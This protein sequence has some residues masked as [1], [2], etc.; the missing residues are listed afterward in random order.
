MKKNQW[1]P[2]TVVIGIAVVISSLLGSSCKKYLDV[3]PD[4]IST[5]DNAFKLRVEAEKYLFTCYSYLPKNGDGWFNASLTSADEIWYAQNDQTNWHPAFMIAEGIQ[6]VANPLF[7]EWRGD[8]KGGDGRYNYLR[9]W[10]AVRNCNIFLENMQNPAKVPDISAAERSRWIGEGLFLKAFYHFYMMRMYGPV[11]LINDNVPVDADLTT[12]YVKRAPVDECVS[13]ISA[14]LDSATARLPERIVNQNTE[15][16]R[17]TKTIALSVKARLLIMAASPLFNGNADYAGF[18]DKEGKAL[19]N[20]TFDASKWVKARDAVKAAIESAEANNFSLYTYTNDVYGLS[21]ATKTQLNIR[22]AVTQRWGQE[23][24][25]G[26]SQSYF[27]NEALCMPPTERG[28]N[29]SR[30]QLQGVWAAPIKIAKLFYTANGV[31]IEEDKTLS[32]NSYDQLRT[33]TS[34]DKYNIE[35]GFVTARINFDREP[36]FY[37]DLGFDGGIW[38]MRDGNS[39]G[40][41]VGTF[42]L[43]TKNSE[44]AGFGHYQNWN[45]TGYFIKKL[46]SWESTTNGQSSPV[47]RQYPW[48]EV[49]LADLYLLY[50]EAENEVNGGSATAITYLDKIRTRAGLKGVAASWSTYSNNPTK[51]TTQAGLRAIIHRERTIEMMFEGQRRWDLCRWKEAADELSKD[52]TGWSIQG[53]TDATF[54]K[55]RYIFSQ[56]FIAPRDYFWP[57]GNYDTRR[58][59]N[60]VE[61]PGW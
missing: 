49:R 44:K 1:K 26:N 36:R 61:N 15:L 53:K 60:L 58:N 54:Y 41:D 6:N 4:D 16:G 50:A 48:P 47:W 21:D 45:E 25:W 9:I 46:V 20:P 57:I 34:A 29:A 8:L 7:N 32:F 40:S 35:P 33:A 23:C 14:W 22:N 27:V 12:S 39:T 51:Y 5:I 56:R 19:F 28:S 3:V 18:K 24:V 30:F 43:K 10:T 38:Y 13:S 55:E 17:I 37:A 31:P 2:G 52:I 11:P 59:P 42:Y